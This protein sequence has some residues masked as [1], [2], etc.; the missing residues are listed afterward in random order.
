V[1]IDDWIG[2]LWDS[3]CVFMRVCVC[4]CCVLTHMKLVSLAAMRGSA[5]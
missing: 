5:M 1:V 2:G 3:M 4:V